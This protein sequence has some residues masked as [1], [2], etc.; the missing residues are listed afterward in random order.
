MT[1]ATIHPFLFDTIHKQILFLEM[2]PRPQGRGSCGSPVSCTCTNLGLPRQG[3]DTYTHVEGAVPKRLKDSQPTA[4][5][6]SQCFYNFLAK[7]SKL[8]FYFLMGLL[9]LEGVH[10]EV[11]TSR[12]RTGS[13]RLLASQKVSRRHGADNT[14]H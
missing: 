2:V 7:V 11:L 14:H 9:Y 6:I 13:H 8:R 12:H 5:G 1:C 3:K 4:V 10:R